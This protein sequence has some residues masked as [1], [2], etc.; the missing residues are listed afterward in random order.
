M[1]VRT[2]L[3]PIDSGHDVLIM[4]YESNESWVTIPMVSAAELSK[5][6]VKEIGQVLADNEG[7]G[8]QYM[9]NRVDI[10][11]SMNGTQP[12]VVEATATD[13]QP[14]EAQ[15]ASSEEPSVEA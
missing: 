9:Q 7:I 14:E 12:E 4:Q 10:F 2:V 5:S 3:F 13:V 6:E 8:R 15:E 1:K 11:H